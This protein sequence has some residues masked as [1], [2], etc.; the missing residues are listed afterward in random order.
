MVSEAVAVVA[1]QSNLVFIECGIIRPLVMLLAGR[2]YLRVKKARW[3]GRWIICAGQLWKGSRVRVVGLESLS[4]L[5]KTR[6][7]AGMRP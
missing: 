6:A 7:R 4:C 3:R 2:G 5:I 1:L